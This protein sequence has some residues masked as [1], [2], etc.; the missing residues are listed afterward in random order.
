MFI[1]WKDRWQQA[2]GSDLG[3]PEGVPELVIEVRSASNSD[4]E[5]E[6][7]GSIYF[8]D[9][10]CLAYWVVDPEEKTV[11]VFSRLESQRL[12]PGQSVALPGKIGGSI[13][14]QDIFE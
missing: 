3:Y 6:Q 4:L 5:L 11:S 1:I 13:S 7:K 2:L 14:L 12:F 10:R 8:S 9:A